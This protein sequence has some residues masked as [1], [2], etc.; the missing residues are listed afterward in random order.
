MNNI[1]RCMWPSK[2]VS[3]LPIPVTGGLE[4]RDFLSPLLVQLFGEQLW[5]S[6]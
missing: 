5:F 1:P 3:S 2:K 4:D 6:R